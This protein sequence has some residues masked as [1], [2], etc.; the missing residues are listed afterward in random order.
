MMVVLDIRFVKS[1][2]TTWLRHGVVNNVQI[3]LHEILVKHLPIIVLEL[4]ETLHAVLM[5]KMLH[6]QVQIG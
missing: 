6:G 3:I 1:L 5:K 4:M 2:H